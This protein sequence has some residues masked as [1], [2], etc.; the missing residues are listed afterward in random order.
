[1]K[2]KIFLLLFALPFFGVGVWM[3]ISISTHLVDAW[4]MRHWEP[5]PAALNDAGCDTLPG[6]DSSSFEAFAQYTYRFGNQEYSGKRVAIAVGADN[7]GDYQMDLGRR[8]GGAWSR[9]E[10]IVVFV[11]PDAPN[12]SIVDRELRWGLI[13]FKSVFVFAFGGVGLGLIIFVLRA[14]KSEDPSNP[15]FHDKP[16]LINDQWQTS[17]VKSDSRTAMLFMLGFAALWNLISAPL[18]FLVYR[19]FPESELR[20]T[21]R[22]AVSTDRHRIAGLGFS[23]NAGVEAFRTGACQ[24]RSFPGRYRRTCRRHDRH[25]IAIRCQRKT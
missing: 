21:V 19:G 17:L 24:A 6:D 10:S 7:I 15:V 13:G 4:Q 22:L 18:P 25:Q 12:E 8:L 9:G 3:L 2:R 1:M 16:W 14:R 11:N 5:V 23:K 20:C